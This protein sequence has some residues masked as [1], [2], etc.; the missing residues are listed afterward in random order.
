[1]SGPYTL[2]N[3]TIDATVTKTSPGNYALG[4]TD[5]GTFMVYYVG[6]ADKDV[7]ARLKRWVGGKTPLFMAPY[8]PTPKAALDK[9]CHNLHD[10]DPPDNKIHP[11]RPNGTSWKGP[12]CKQFG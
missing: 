2:D 6:R 4:H 11:D 12:R 8:A 7:R 9:E 1:M 3:D 10:F 5:N